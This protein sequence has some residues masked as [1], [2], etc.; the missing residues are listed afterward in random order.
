M[1]RVGLTGGLGSGKS[2]VAGMLAAL[3]AQ[4]LSADE[5]GRQMMQPGE[6]VFRAIVDHFGPKVVTSAGVLDRTMLA[7]LSFV[8]GR[9]AELNAIVHPAVI[10][11]QAVLA[12]ELASRRPDAVLV[13]ESALLFE[14]EHGGENGCR[15]RFDRILLVTASEQNKIGRFVRRT[16]TSSSLDVMARHE[17]ARHRLSHQIDDA[18]KSRWADFVVDNDGSLE[19]LERQVRRLWPRLLAEASA[20]P[21]SRPLA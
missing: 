4:V 17:D 1:L 2:T 5:L 8:E 15:S 16:A 3:G 19:D 20:A 21:V 10:A 9:L 12:A 7:R 13:V 11:R 18:E 6:P 14:T